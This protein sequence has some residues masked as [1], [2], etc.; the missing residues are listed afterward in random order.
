[1]MET[2]DRILQHNDDGQG[3]RSCAWKKECDDLKERS[4]ITKCSVIRTDLKNSYK[5]RYA[6]KF[7][8]MPLIEEAESGAN[9]WVRKNTLFV[10]GIDDCPKETHC[11]FK[12]PQ[13]S[14]NTTCSYSGVDGWVMIPYRGTPGDPCVFPTVEDCSDVEEESEDMG[15]EYVVVKN[16]NYKDIV[17]S[18]I[19]P[20]IFKRMARKGGG[21]TWD[22]N[23]GDI[24]SNPD[25]WMV[26][27]GFSDELLRLGF[28]EEKVCDPIV[29]IGDVFRRIN[30][31]YY[32]M[33]HAFNGTYNLVSMKEGFNIKPPE[34]VECHSTNLS[35]LVGKSR[36][37]EFKP[38]KIEIREV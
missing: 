8:I 4:G 13:T 30:G 31:D 16:A 18:D 22:V 34:I 11:R 25:F 17:E 23:K 35:D 19:D 27:M 29:N 21:M 14:K 33:C 6:N 15:K 28:I 37:S 36:L 3:C 12:K 1:M 7:Q 38:V 26:K 2:Y 5:S 20:I 32:L 24:L 10:C 9:E